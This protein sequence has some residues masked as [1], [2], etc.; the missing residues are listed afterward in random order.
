MKLTYTAA[1]LLSLHT[2]ANAADSTPC[3]DIVRH[4]TAAVGSFLINRCTGETWLLTGN[5]RWAPVGVDKTPVA[6][7]PD[8]PGPGR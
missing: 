6:P 5:M 4:P 7:R 1:L 3:F 8:S 2:A